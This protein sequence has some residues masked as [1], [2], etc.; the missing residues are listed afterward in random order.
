MVYDRVPPSDVDPQE[1]HVYCEEHGCFR[2]KD[3]YGNLIC[4][5]CLVEDRLEL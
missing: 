2:I 3:L 1:E 5:V 4:V